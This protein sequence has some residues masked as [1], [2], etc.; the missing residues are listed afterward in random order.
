MLC[1]NKK[2]QNEF[3]PKTSN[4]K[5]CSVKCR[6]Q[7]GSRSWRNKNSNYCKICNKKIKFSASY[8]KK[9]L[10][11]LKTEEYKE[12]TIKE[13]QDKKYLQGKH[14]S[15]KNA[16]LRLFARS[17]NKELISQPCQKCGYN[18]HIE[19]AHIKAVSK[20]DLDTKLGI[21][22]DPSNLLILCKNHHWELDHGFLKMKDIPGRDRTHIN[23]P[24]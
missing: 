17:W 1:K 5:F 23:L 16:N 13:Y 10:G 9:C 8:C 3:E 14:P 20:F 12:K 21:V 2:C 22:N 6:N 24:S 11:I 15:C 7:V 19:F 18:L 4:Q